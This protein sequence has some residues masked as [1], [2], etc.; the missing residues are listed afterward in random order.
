MVQC[1]PMLRNTHPQNTNVP[2]QR[3]ADL[4]N[5]RCGE[6]TRPVSHGRAPLQARRPSR[7][8]RVPQNLWLTPL[9]KSA[10]PRRKQENLKGF[11]GSPTPRKACTRHQWEC[12]QAS[13][14]RAWSAA[15]CRSRF[16]RRPP[17]RGKFVDQPLMLGRRRRWANGPVQTLR[18]NEPFE[19]QNQTGTHDWPT[20]IADPTSRVGPKTP[21]TSEGADE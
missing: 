6:H 3:P 21:L 13:R 4:T 15:C 7:P 19:K 1:A 18:R 11:Q 12:R 20:T 16:S 8:T 10:T 5:Q 9:Y 14:C 2:K 17:S